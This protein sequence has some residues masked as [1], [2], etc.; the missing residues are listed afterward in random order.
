[1]ILYMLLLLLSIYSIS[2]RKNELYNCMSQ[3]VEDTLFIYFGNENA[4]EELIL[5]SIHT[6]LEKRLT[7]D[8]GRE[9]VLTVCDMEKGILGLRVLETFYLPNGFYKTVV[10]EKTAIV[11]LQEGEDMVW[12]GE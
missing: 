5:D 1:M 2:A 6:M 3:V 10:L 11:D 12:Q 9:I 4:D 8:S 7:S